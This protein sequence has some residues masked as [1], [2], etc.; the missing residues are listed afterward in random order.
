MKAILRALLGRWLV[1]AIS[2]AAC[3]IGGLVVIATS[4]PRYKGT[5]RVVLDYIQP[6][7][8]TGAVLPSK[9]LDAYIM[10]QVN[11]IR[12]F[13]VTGPAV[14]ALG[15]VDNP[16]IQ[17]AYYANPPADGRD[18]H[19]WIA[20]QVGAAA[21]GSMIEDSNILEIAYIASSPELAASVADALRAAY[22][23]SSAAQTR[24]A[25]EERAAAL[26]ARVEASKRSLAQLEAMQ[27]RLEDQTGISM[28]ESGRDE[29]AAKLESLMRRG[30]AP[31][32]LDGPR[33][34]AASILLG[35][36]DAEIAQASNTLGPN[37]P[38]LAA[39]QRRRAGLQ[40]QVDVE[41]QRTA[42]MANL[43][44]AS[45]QA[46]AAQVQQQMNRVLDAREPTL[47]LRLLQDEI[48]RQRTSIND[49][50]EAV[51]QARTLS[52]ANT[53]T[54][55]PIGPAEA[56]KE[57]VFPNKPLI[58]LGSAGLG[59]V[60]GSLLAIFVELMGRRIRAARDL[61]AATRVRVLAEI[62]DYSRPR[63][64]RPR[65]TQRAEA[66]PKDKQPLEPAMAAE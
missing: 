42:S 60:G 45:E 5:A 20:A 50:T 6:D 10:S 38:R 52:A 23:E 3:L 11:L 24:R 26:S 4:P 32:I 27:N 9:M 43:V 8:T 7:P 34:S 31:L 54:T 15:F 59:L 37:N 14:E 30:R 57:P 53:S 62:P 16:D 1:V 65:R 12:D 51:I 56:E 33:E 47:R 28:S 29:E 58:L 61:E 13:Q 19:S 2:V 25:A 22:T 36:M 21:G 49:M 66:P 39:M 55:T 63:R 17:A 46:A 35:Q 18:L 40:A 64:R 44:V 48:N 41:R